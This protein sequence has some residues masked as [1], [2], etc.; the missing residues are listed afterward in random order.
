MQPKL[1]CIGSTSVLRAREPLSRGLAPAGCA[2]DRAEYQLG[3]AKYHQSTWRPPLARSS[4]ESPDAQLSLERRQG[5][6]HAIMT[7]RTLNRSTRA[8]A[9]CSTA[10]DALCSP[11]AHLDTF[12][13]FHI[14]LAIL[15]QRGLITAR[16]PPAGTHQLLHCP[17]PRFSASSLHDAGPSDTLRPTPAA[18]TTRPKQR[19]VVTTRQHVGA[20]RRIWLNS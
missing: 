9:S 1:L 11:H 13:T 4:G 7:T 16:D 6:I 15:Y 10:C 3:V 17:L 14:A 8:H 5:H 2:F 20:S 19:A 12:G 18:S